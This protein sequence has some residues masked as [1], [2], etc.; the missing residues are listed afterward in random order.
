MS[1]TEKVIENTFHAVRSV[2]FLSSFFKENPR[3]ARLELDVYACATFLKCYAWQTENRADT[4]K[5][6]TVLS[7]VADLE[8]LNAKTRE[9]Y[10]QKEITRQ[11]LGLFQQIDRA[12]SID[13]KSRD[14]DDDALER[15]SNLI[16]GKE[17]KDYEEKS[18]LDFTLSVKPS[19]IPNAGDGLFIKNLGPRQYISA[20]S[21]I[22]IF[23]GVVHLKEYT[24]N[25]K[26]VSAL[27]PDPDFQLTLTAGGHV[28][29]SRQLDKI[30]YN[31]IALAHKVNHVPEGKTPNA[32]AISYG[33]ST[34]RTGEDGFPYRF[35][36]YI[37]NIYAKQ[38]FA[39]DR[40]QI[41]RTKVLVTSRPISDG[42]EI[43]MD[44][45]LNVDTMKYPFWYIP[46]VSPY[47]IDSSSTTPTTRSP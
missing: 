20:G 26:Y 47:S 40:S 28:I 18:L 42:E 41:M 13:E 19:S 23:P 36:K 46:Y 45:R 34:F 12:N 33:F 21:V 6:D 16:F 17:V 30:P 22:A 27:F 7:F 37:P 8:K 24:R 38:P 3:A 1:K 10:V 29:D 15:M 31:P 5:K 25:Q 35:R 11:I 43:F 9:N 39:T 44:Y 4:I 14:N 32:I 2:P